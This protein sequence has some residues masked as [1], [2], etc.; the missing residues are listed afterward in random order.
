M[1]AEFRHGPDLVVRTRDLRNFT[2][3]EAKEI[4]TDSGEE[5]QMPVGAESDGASTP[6][7]LWTIGLTPFGPEGPADYAHDCAYRGTLL[8]K[9]DGAWVPAM[10]AKSESDDLY[11]ALMFS[12]GVSEKRRLVIYSGVK[13]GGWRAFREDRAVADTDL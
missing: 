3:V 7:I 11:N 13:F 6:Q 2:L 10:L 12:L 9:R 8:V 1:T 5:Y 4:V